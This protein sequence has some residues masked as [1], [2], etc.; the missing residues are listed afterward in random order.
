MSSISL[1]VAS[2]YF[3]IQHYFPFRF[4]WSGN[5]PLRLWLFWQNQ[6]Q[7]LFKFYVHKWSG[8]DQTIL[9]FS[10]CFASNTSIVPLQTVYLTTY[11]TWAMTK[12]YLMLY[13]ALIYRSSLCYCGFCFK[14]FVWI[15]L[16][17]QKLLEKLGSVCWKFA[18]E[19]SS[20]TLAYCVILN[21]RHVAWYF[22]NRY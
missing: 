11:I 21:E 19:E 5:H 3:L 2:I 8:V 22:E 14:N 9:V 15:D 20:L 6:I 17:S 10:I 18:L 4:L 13:S 12:Q 7:I 16:N 1:L